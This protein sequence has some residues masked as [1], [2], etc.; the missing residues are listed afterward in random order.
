MSCKDVGDEVRKETLEVHTTLLEIHNN[1]G[2]R[3]GNEVVVGS[4]RDS[5]KRRRVSSPGSVVSC[6][7]KKTSREEAC[8]AIARFFYNNVIRLD[9]VK[10]D[11]FITMCDMVSKHGVGFKPPSFDEIKGKYL[12]DEVEFTMEALAEHRAVW[13]ITG[14]TI[15]VD[16]WYDEKEFRD[17]LNFFVNSPKGTFF[18]KSVESADISSPE[19]LFKMMDDIVEEVGE[20]NVVQI[21]T[22]SATY[23]EKAGE[24]L[25][26][27]RTR[28]YWT[29][30]ATRCIEMILKEYE[31]IPIYKETTEKCRRIVM[32][33]YSSD[34]LIS[35]LQHFAKGVNLFGMETVICVLYCLSLCCLHENREALIR[36]FT[37]KRWK[38]NE[39][40]ET[41]NGK[42]VEDLVLDKEFWKDVMICYKGANPLVQVLRLVS[43][44]DE[45][46]MGFIYEAMEKAKELIQ[47]LSKSGIE[48]FKPL[49]EIIDKGW[50]KQLQSPLYAA[51]YFLNPQ[52]HYSPGFR[53]DIKVKLGLH[54][55]ITRMVADPEERAKI[56][57]QLEDFDKQA[58]VFGQ[59]IPVVTADEE[60]PPVWWASII[61]GQPELQK[62]A[63]RVLCLA[64]SSYGGERNKS[65][66][67]MVHAK[68]STNE[69]EDQKTDNNVLFV[70][71]NSKWTEKKR[72]SIQLNL[73]DNGDVDALDVGD[74]DLI[75]PCLKPQDDVGIDGLHDENAN[76]DEDENEDGDEMGDSN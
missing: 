56:E 12:T 19:E 20:E 38:S 2:K 34:S 52:F 70:M 42:F 33:I 65:A 75:I 37:S 45:P 66:F 14:C 76:G 32:F 29:P 21:V 6:K 58:N 63:I 36:M 35:L 1:G 43:S 71:A 51:G 62:F 73:D 57:I 15:M 23:Y 24:M 26:K 28:L 13:K 67:E 31:Q 53:D 44:I 74:L 27:K 9:A 61:D 59:P 68:R 72:S 11:E 7:N 47:R 64:C 46:A 49:Q 10:S 60:T 18:L 3:K 54:D 22:D 30:C 41:K 69:R 4:S 40:A 25:M 50:D 39:F 48:S 17:I 16:D 55:C 5:F 8:Q